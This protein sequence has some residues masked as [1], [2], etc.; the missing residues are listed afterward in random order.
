MEPLKTTY[1]VRGETVTVVTEPLRTHPQGDARRAYEASGLDVDSRQHRAA[2]PNQGCGAHGTR[3]LRD[4]HALP[5]RLLDMVKT[6][7]LDAEA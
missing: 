3:K 1:R 2:P 5:A 7:W 4:A 6:R